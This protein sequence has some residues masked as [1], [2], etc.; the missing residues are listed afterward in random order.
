MRN[1]VAGQLDELRHAARRLRTSPGFT[2][3]AALALAIGIGGTATL[4]S[5]A[6]AL[7]L[8]DLPGVGAP[9][10][11]V[12]V[13]RVLPDGSRER[14]SAPDYRD[15]AERLAD[16]PAL[17]GLAGFSD[18]G[19]SLAV[20]SA[21]EAGD[22]ELV[23]AQV[24]TGDY[25]RVLRAEPAIGRFFTGDEVGDDAAPGANPVAVLSHAL[26]QRRFGGDPDLVGRDV[27]INGHPF[28]VV[29]VASE[30]FGGTFVGFVFD[31]WVPLSMAEVADPQ[32]DLDDRS[33]PLLELVGRLPAD[34]GGVDRAAGIERLQPRVQALAERL[35]RAHPEVHE[36]LDVAVVPTTGY[37]QGFREGVT[38]F[39]A[40]LGA[41]ALLVLLMACASVGNMLLARA[42]E[43]RREVAVRLALGA[44]RGRI[45]RQLL[46]ESVLLALVGGAAGL[47][48]AYWGIESLRAFE[49]PLSLPLVF[50]VE[51]DARVLAFS[52]VTSLAAGVLFG[53]APALRVSRPHRAGLATALREVMGADRRRSWLRRAF[54]VSQVA[55]SL[56]L[57]V[58]TG[59]LFRTL[60][61]AATADL[62][63]EP[64]RVETV[65]LDPRVL[66]VEP[67]D[68]PAFFGALSER[69]SALPAVRAVSLTS[70]VPLGISAVLGPST[71][72]LSVPG[73]EPPPDGTDSPRWRVEHAR[74]GPGYF[75][76]MG[77]RLVAGRGIEEGDRADSLP[78]AVVNTTLAERLWPG[79]SALGRR[80]LR[81]DGTGLTVVGVAAAGRYRFPG[82]EP[83]PFVYLPYAQDP[84]ARAT[85]LL[86]T[87][88]PPELVEP[89]IR[90][91][92]R[93]AEPDL[94]VLSLEPLERAIAISVLPQRMAAAVAGV[95][96]LIGLVLAALGLYGVVAQSVSGRVRE[97]GVRL[98]LGAR[99]RDLV[100][101][102]VGDG[103][104]LAGAG[105]VAGLVLALLVTRFLES[106]LFGVGAADPL[107][108]AAVAAFLLGVAFLASWLPARRVAAIDPTVAMRGDG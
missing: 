108:F 90:R 30:R 37:D 65:S 36:E 80:L 100:R 70:R 42:A 7:L 76:T 17:A 31:L 61:H 82:E 78:V 32:V 75:R 54:V 49:P 67:E 59:L 5:L 16:D 12:N 68:G 13:H 57:L 47:L 9:D 79:E 87:E 103:M 85:L 35:R 18:R 43:R 48:V 27:Q 88:G 44:G 92:L 29:G 53:L 96:G 66:G 64:E 60:H 71:V 21:G 86:A 20:P 6:D 52:F 74:V 23:L 106:L 91:E 11:L 101:M 45:V 55:G 58:A 95:L 73:V 40:V 33:Q 34:G 50:H 94:P 107:T 102:V 51:M 56:L 22:A 98:S 62:G 26:W 77:V 99:H 41:I 97:L 84:T 39:L 10:E 28:T 104:K 38:A 15:L 25:F 3:V 14:F 89:A 105:V 83:T 8:R 69:L 24:V 81:E 72:A 46:A 63:F 93:A 2:A 19:L 4:F 1:P